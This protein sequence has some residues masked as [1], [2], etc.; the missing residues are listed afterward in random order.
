MK[1]TL[2]QTNGLQPSV[3]G[4]H[5]DDVETT[6]TKTRGPIDDRGFAWGSNGE[7]VR[8]DAKGDDVG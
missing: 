5:V 1:N 4:H 3:S 7:A 6:V 2:T 8:V